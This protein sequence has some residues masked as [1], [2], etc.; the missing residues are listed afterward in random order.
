MNIS[1]ST[2]IV[3]IIGTWFILTV[4]ADVPSTED[5]A[6]ALA[7]SVAVTATFVVGPEA[8]DKLGYT[9]GNGNAG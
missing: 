3:G 8:A 4:I 6:T 5:L 7:L 1:Y 2:W 9:K